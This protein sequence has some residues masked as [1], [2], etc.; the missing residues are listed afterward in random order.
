MR[1]KKK[2]QRGTTLKERPFSYR[3]RNDG[4]VAIFWKRIP[5]TVLAGKLAENFLAAVPE[6]TDAEQQLL[7]VKATG[8]FK[9]GNERP[10]KARPSGRS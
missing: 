5:A 7:M 3:A 2:Q 4:T 10:K 6:A 9:R 1:P 8:N